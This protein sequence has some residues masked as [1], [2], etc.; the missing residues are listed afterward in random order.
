MIDHQASPRRSVRLRM[1]AIDDHDWDRAACVDDDSHLISWQI[2]RRPRM[3]FSIA[4]THIQSGQVSCIHLSRRFSRVFHFLVHGSFTANT[5]NLGRSPDPLVHSHEGDTPASRAIISFSSITMERLSR[6][7]SVRGG[8]RPASHAL[9]HFPPLPWKDFRFCFAGTRPQLH[10]RCTGR[11]HGRGHI[12][13]LS[14][15]LLKKLNGTENYQADRMKK[16]WQGKR[17]HH[18]LS[19]TSPLARN[20]IY[21]I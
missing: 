10:V 14:L 21:S 11:A 20:I 4:Y 19:F 13:E 9:T 17:R 18:H 7:L 12:I 2:G 5:E 3:G 8:D 1:Y 6:R 15:A 16:Q